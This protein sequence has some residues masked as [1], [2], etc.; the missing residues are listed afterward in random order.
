MKICRFDDD[1]IGLVR[2]GAIHDVTE[3]LSAL[4]EQRYPYPVGDALISNLAELAPRM[5][6]LADKAPPIDP[7]TVSL[8]SPVANP[9]KLVCAPVNYL[10]HFDEGA[11]DPEIHF[12]RHVA[13]IHEVALFLKANSALAGAGDGVQ[14]RHL[15]RRSD[16]EIELALVIGKAA[17]RVSREDALDHVAGYMIGLDMTVRGPESRSFRKSIDSYAVLGPWMV[18]ADEIDDPAQLGMELT[19]NG[20][21]RQ[22]ANTRDLVVP[23][24][25]LIEWASSF[26]TLHPGDVIFTGTPEGVGPVVPGD[27]INATIDAIGTMS[28]AVSAA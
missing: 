8:R 25:E 21:G 28:V 3:A 23:I 13:K 1:R 4:P 16:H 2:E 10:K 27:T 15:D 22:K 17:D 26:Y 6:E 5:E 12:N 19:V 11:G 9:T 24:P 20:E 18:T 14:L 7:A